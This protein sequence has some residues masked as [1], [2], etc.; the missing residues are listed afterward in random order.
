MTVPVRHFVLVHTLT[1]ALIL[2]HVGALLGL[3]LFLVG[4]LRRDL[5]SQ[6]QSTVADRIGLTSTVPSG[7]ASSS[8]TASPEWPRES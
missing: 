7:N 1:S 8:F 3:A 2:S 6:K 4:S 5:A